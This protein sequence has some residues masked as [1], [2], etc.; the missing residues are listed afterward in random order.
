MPR[1]GAACG[2]L[3]RVQNPFAP[4]SPLQRCD[5]VFAG[6]Q[7]A[8]VHGSYDGRSVHSG[9]NRYTSCGVRRWDQ[10]AFLFPIRVAPPPQ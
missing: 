4:T 1:P 2:K 7:T 10:L 9:F 3:V 8:N 6:V 5:P